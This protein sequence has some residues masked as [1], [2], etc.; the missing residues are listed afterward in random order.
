MVEV[1]WADVLAIPNIITLLRL[2]LLPLFLYL[3]FGREDRLAAAIVLGSMGATDWI[4]G[5]VA[6]KFDMVTDLGKLLDP[7]ADRIMLITA[8]VALI[9]DNAI[10]RWVGLLALV[11]EAVVAA[12]ALIIGALG[13]R[14]FDVTFIG[15]TGAFLMMFAFPLFC[16]GASTAVVADVAWVLGWAFAIPGLAISYW[17]AVG[18]FPLARDALVEG[19]AA[20]IEELP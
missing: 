12:I 13:A 20:R 10:P 3:L 9:I 6:R 1:R 15:K 4:D 16:A 18:Y 2:L 7:V 5:W 11:R 14:R 8:V 19:R 17:S